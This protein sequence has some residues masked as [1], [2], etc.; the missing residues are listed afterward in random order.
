[1]VTDVLFS[2]VPSILRSFANFP[3]H[4]L[5]HY[6]LPV[7]LNPVQSCGSGAAG[8]K[9]L[10]LKLRKG[11]LRAG[12]MGP[13]VVLVPLAFY[14]ELFVQSRILILL[15]GHLPF[16]IEV[17]VPYVFPVS[18]LKNVRNLLYRVGYLSTDWQCLGTVP[19]VPQYHAV[20]WIRNVSCKC[21]R[22]Q[23]MTRYKLFREFF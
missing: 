12:Y 14:L 10:L 16:N 11:S 20:L 7:P 6:P 21:V 1:M 22:L 13:T 2:M 23:I 9:I 18:R 5:F 4:L 19:T 17:P 3:T 8:T 15:D